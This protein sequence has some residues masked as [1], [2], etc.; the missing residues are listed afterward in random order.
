VGDFDWLTDVHKE[1]W[2][3]A[4]RACSLKYGVIFLCIGRSPRPKRSLESRKAWL[5]A[6]RGSRLMKYYSNTS[7]R[8]KERW[9]PAKRACS[10]KYGVIFLC[11]GRSPRPKRSLE[12]RKAWLKAKRGSRLMKCYSNTSVRT[13]SKPVRVTEFYTP[14]GYLCI[15]FTIGIPPLSRGI[16]AKKSSDRQFSGS[17]CLM[18]IKTPSLFD[19]KAL[20]C[21]SNIRKIF[22]QPILD[23]KNAL[24]SKTLCLC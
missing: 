8:T 5:K 22:N 13:K 19:I 20:H 16:R 1:R 2:R 7:V 11:I 17:R 9:Q 3:H 10:L 12:S 14:L 6:K 15:S 21:F 4:K 23:L 24:M 18:S